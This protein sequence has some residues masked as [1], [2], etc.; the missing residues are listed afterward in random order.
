M[1]LHGMKVVEAGV[2]TAGSF[3][4][5]LM[6]QLGATVTKLVPPNYTST[7]TTDIG[8]YIQAY[9]ETRSSVVNY[10]RE[11]TIVLVDLAEHPAHLG[12]ESAIPY[13]D[14][15]HRAN[16]GVWVTISPKGLCGGEDNKA[17]TDLTLSARGGLAWFTRDPDTNRPRTLAGSQAMLSAGQIAVLAALHGV[18]ISRQNRRPVHIDVAARDAVI[19]TGIL[20]QCNAYLLGASEGLS[21][22]TPSP[23]GYYKCL[24]GLIRLVAME[25]HHWQ[26]L[27]S[28][29]GDR[30][31]TFQFDAIEE[32][33]RRPAE[34]D[35]LIESWT[36]QCLKFDVEARLQ[37]MGVPAAAVRSW[38]ELC[39]SDQLAARASVT[40]SASYDLPLIRHP[41]GQNYCPRKTSEPTARDTWRENDEIDY[42]AFA[43][44]KILD[45]GQ[46]LAVPLAT[47]LLGAMGAQVL[48][49][50][51]P[52]RMDLFRRR[53]PFVDGIPGT[54]RSAH[55]AVANHS[56]RSETISFEHDS[57]RLRQLILDSDIVIENMG[58]RRSTM[59]GVDS[60]SVA[61]IGGSRLG[62]S[63]SAFGHSGPLRDYRAY[64]SIL[65]AYSGLAFLSANERG[66]PPE[67]ENPWSDLLAA[68]SLATV[69]AAW[70][71]GRSP[72]YDASGTDIDFSM[73]EA[74]A[75]R[76]NDAST[77]PESAHPSMLDLVVGD[78]SIDA[79]LAISVRHETD[80]S[81]ILRYLDSFFGGREHG[82]VPGLAA[83]LDSVSEMIGVEA[84]E[85]A[86]RGLGIRCAHVL[87]PADIVRDVS[88]YGRLFVK[89]D[90]DWGPGHLIGLPWQIVAH[91]A[92][93]AL[94]GPPSLE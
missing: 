16:E 73:A 49:L 80:V 78:A 37:R 92:G 57:E 86:L 61:A 13:M 3:A 30:S 52:R 68:V 60:A 7:S 42:V 76:F 33:K 71:L 28:V 65:N 90:A 11:A 2:G 45:L 75:F 41:Y 51:D 84:L 53:G 5:S 8:K 44:L 62:V 18:D 66:I 35:E 34:V 31:S 46:V 43:D 50:E 24:D 58:Y 40:H 27:C 89:F 83:E 23:S 29:L 38:Q 9:D 93:S 94:T 72:E 19:F 22:I 47:S 74:V 55:F 79:W 17:D 69:V 48:K 1:F 70:A 81:R 77:P 21:R 67:T 10:A 26:S 36:S 91:D 63:S 15:V 87:S 14:F 85:S 25:D 64:A 12:G 59:Y 54:N 6:V 56:K 20:P 82:T 4:G 32:R 88:L 39:S